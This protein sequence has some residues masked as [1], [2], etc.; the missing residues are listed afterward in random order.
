M[1]LNGI[2]TSRLYY[3]LENFRKTHSDYPTEIET[4]PRRSCI[5]QLTRYHNLVAY[6]VDSSRLMITGLR[7]ELVTDP[8]V[9]R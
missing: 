4:L 1:N 7:N 8:C 2:Q 3:H 5:G 9:S 6:S